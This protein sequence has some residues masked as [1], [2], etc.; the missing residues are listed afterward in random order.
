MRYFSFLLAFAGLITNTIAPAKAQSGGAATAHAVI[1]WNGYAEVPTRGAR[2]QRVPTFEKAYHGLDEQ[3]GLFGLRLEGAVDQGQL[4]NTVYQPFT[5]T[6]A[7]LFDASKLPAGP[8]PRL[9]QGTEMKR[10]VTHLSLRTVRRNPQTG[11]PE[12]LVSFDYVYTPGSGAATAARRVQSRTHATNS[13]LAN[14]DWYKVGVAESGIYKIDLATLRDLGVNTQGLDPSRVRIYGNSTGILPQAN[15][16]YR[17][18]DLV[19]NAVQFV[20]NTDNS[21]DNNE[22]LLFYSPGAHTWEAQG[23]LFRHRNNIYTDTTYY[24]ITVGNAPGRRVS[25]VAAPPVSGNVPAISTFADRQFYE[26]DLVSLL[27]S[28]RQWLGEGF[29]PNSQRTFTFN[30]PDLVPGGPLRVTSSTAA[31]SSVG[32]TFRISVSGAS[33]N[34]TQIGTQGLAPK[35]TYDYGAIAMVATNTYQTALPSGVGPE[36]RVN[37]A[38]SSGDAT[39]S[40]YLD[41]LE[42]NAQ[43]QLRMSGD[44]L[45]F[46]SL[47]NIAPQAVSRFTLGNGIGVTV[48]DVTNPRNAKAQAFDGTSFLALTDTLREYVAF[49]PAGN[50]PTPRRFGR[51]ANQNL[52]ALNANPSNLL[53][54]VIV[55][56][57]PFRAQAERL[58]D[59]RRTRQGM[60]VA[61]VTTTEVY[62]EYGS[63]GQDLTAIRDLMKQLYDR[64][65]AGKQM[66][67]LLFGDA[68]FDY[69]SDPFNNKAFEPAW[70]ADRTPF[71]SDA[72]FDRGYGRPTRP[73][74]TLCC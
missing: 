33:G 64:A 69:K 17:P 16:V 4:T 3:V 15:D 39:A 36:V 56:Y 45:E 12:R 10:P 43:R 72:D 44:Q 8:E 50:F 26:H 37:L 19:E 34:Q 66:Q 28:G 63:G 5:A 14:G 35:P 55:T 51:V 70:W 21:F 38:Y 13:V 58:A 22:Y 67:L 1:K 27:R 29:S 24:F 53:D 30:F 23:G 46:R 42:I 20:G 74:Q 71:R 54:L 9:V 62:N 6:D 40:G 49:R 11:Q 52:H 59:H 7:K 31:N 61:V 73:A 48:W 57:P 18:D 41:Y 32:S 25:T 47:E 68:S 65:P 60:R 2:K